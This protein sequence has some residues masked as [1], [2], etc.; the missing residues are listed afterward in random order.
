MKTVY[1]LESVIKESAL[2]IREVILKIGR[3]H[4]LSH[5]C[6]NIGASDGISLDLIKPLVL[7]GEFGGVAIEGDS[8]IFKSLSRNLPDSV[9]KI[10]AMVTP[11]NIMNILRD[12]EV[13]KSPD[14]ID[15]DIDGYDYFVV[16]QVIRLEPKILTV[17]LNEDIP[18]GIKY[19][20]VYDPDYVWGK[21]RPWG[22]SIDMVTSLGRIHGYKLLMMDWN[23]LVLV[24]SDYASLF[25]LPKSTSEAFFSGWYDRPG[26]IE[27]FNWKSSENPLIGMEPQKMY[28][29]LLNIYKPYLNEI[30]LEITND[31]L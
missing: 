25:D 16:Q 12:A 13:P 1:T 3:S 31:F 22:C 30:I 20:R 11:Y 29:S 23:N 28:E 4:E 21:G 26:R 7:S 18:P 15:V 14:I 19:T 17:E 2:K 6:V 8:E 10:N 27:A 9:K 24:H 5:F